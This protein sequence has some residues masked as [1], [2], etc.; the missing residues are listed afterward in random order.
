MKSE[1]T[2]EPYWN[3]RGVPSGLNVMP[4]GPPVPRVFV[5]S[6]GLVKVLITPVG[7]MVD[8]RTPGRMLF[9]G[10]CVAGT[11]AGRPKFST[12]AAHHA[13]S[14]QVPTPVL[15]SYST[16]PIQWPRSPQNGMPPARLAAVV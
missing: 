7:E 8:G 10:I 15:R 6:A 12:S 11:P 5:E 1:L 4:T 13:R 14:V 2:S 9:A 16:A 3:L